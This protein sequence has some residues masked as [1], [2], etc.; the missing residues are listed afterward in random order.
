MRKI[1]LLDHPQV[2]SY[3]DPAP[4]HGLSFQR[5]REVWD[6][7]PVPLLPF[8]LSNVR[9]R[10]GA[11]TVPWCPVRRALQPRRRVSSGPLSRHTEL[12]QHPK[13]G[14]PLCRL[15][16]RAGARDLGGSGV[17]LTHAPP[18]RHLLALPAFKTTAKPEKI[19]VGQRRWL[20]W[21]PALQGPRVSKHRPPPPGQRKLAEQRGRGAEQG[22]EP[23]GP[24]DN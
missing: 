9:E 17:Q 6:C 5:W 22:L 11:P 7:V 1:Q 8:P 14:R 20:I 10:A 18:S 21:G 2:L 15:G 13:G 19:R 4:V 24:P 23:E 12:P 16:R 3:R